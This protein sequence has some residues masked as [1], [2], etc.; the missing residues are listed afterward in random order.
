[1]KLK[2]MKTKSL[3]AGILYFPGTN[4]EKDLKMALDS[5]G[6]RSE[7]LWHTD[8]FEVTHDLYFV[9]GG[10]SYG[11]YL[12]SGALAAR[13]LSLQSLK[14]AQKKERMI[15]GICN[16]FQILTEAA[17]LPGAL[18]R[19]TGLVHICKW[20]DLSPAGIFQKA[21]D[22]DFQL[23]VSHSEGNFIAEPDVL[24]KI[25]DEDRVIL[26]YK[27]NVNGSAANIAGITDETGRTIGLMPHPERAMNISKDN[28]YSQNLAG[29]YFFDAVFDRL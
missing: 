9:P 13:S 17:L 7:Y 18:I 22:R 27:E 20:V 6:I 28:P 2:K 19:N 8:R 3:K 26:K 25:L 4:C 29:K 23:P 5:Y 15:V 12:R 14:E 11:D 21:I 16:G 1:M 10:F 24:K